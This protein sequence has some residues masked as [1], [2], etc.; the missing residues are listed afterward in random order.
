MGPRWHGP[1]TSNSTHAPRHRIAALVWNPGGLSR[2]KLLEFLIWADRQSTGIFVLPEARWAFESMWE[3]DRWLFVHSGPASGRSAGILIIISKKLCTGDLLTMSYRTIIPGR[4]VHLR[5]HL[6]PRYL[7]ILACYQYAGHTGVDMADRASFWTSLNETLHSLAHRHGL[8]MAGDFNCCLTAGYPTT[9]TNVF[10]HGGRQMLGTQHKDRAMFNQLVMHH[11]LVALNCWDA[12]LGPT[13]SNPL[14]AVSRIDFVFLRQKSVDAQSRR[15]VHLTE[16][17]FA[18]DQGAH[19]IPLLCN[20]ALPC[21]PRSTAKEQQLRLKH[22]QNGRDAR[23]AGTDHWQLF[24]RELQQVVDRE[25][26]LPSWPVEGLPR[27]PEPL[28]HSE[29]VFSHANLISQG[30]FETMLDNCHAHALQCFRTFFARPSILEER[31]SEPTLDAPLTSFQV[32]KP[33][34][35]HFHAFHKPTLITSRSV[36]HAWWHMTQFDLRRKQHA[37]LVHSS[38][39]QRISEVIGTAAKAADNHDSYTLFACIRSLMPRVDSKIKLRNT[40]GQ[41]MNTVEEVACFRAHIRT[42]WQGP[43]N[44]PSYGWLTDMPFDREALIRALELTPE[45]KAVAPGRAP[46]TVWKLQ[47]ERIGSWLFDLLCHLWVGRPPVIP[48]SWKDGWLHFI[49]KPGKAPSHPAFLRPLAL[50]DPVGKVVMKLVATRIREQAW[51]ALVEWPQYAYLPFRSTFDPVSRVAQHC[52]DARQLRLQQRLT[53]HDRANGVSGF[54]ICGALQVFLD[55]DKAFDNAPRDQLIHGLVECGVDEGL[56]TLMGEW[57]TGT[58]Y[59]Y[60]H[61]SNSICEPSGKGVRQGCTGAPILWA[62]LMTRF[63]ATLVSQCSPTMDSALHQHFC[64]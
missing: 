37:R 29:A 45:T 31:C 63:F 44:C 54:A 49:Y 48:Q 4:L 59:H 40:Q 50:T 17:P 20:F 1:L 56:A 19:H 3:T 2:S 53:Q 16:A 47:A 58:R 62:V 23:L 15:V 13:S 24:T 35:T 64:G 5:L 51:P 21:A 6:V 52:R 27:A 43:A 42:T 11:G 32:I 14:G 30:D 36:F 41:L 46:G 39:M 28:A 60:N 7:N 33:K 9:G 25:L 18:H 57:H 34:W 22:R 61:L 38:K 10:T 8:V 26:T 12:T 55:V